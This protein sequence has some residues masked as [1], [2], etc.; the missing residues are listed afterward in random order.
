MPFFN[1]PLAQLVEHR[2]PKS[3]V[4]VQVLHGVPDSKPLEFDTFKTPE[5]IM[6]TIKYQNNEFQFNDVHIAR[7]GDKAWD[8]AWGIADEFGYLAP[9]VIESLPDEDNNEMILAVDREDKCKAECIAI[10]CSKEKSPMFP[11]LTEDARCM[12]FQFVYEGDQFEVL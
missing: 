6:K 9:C 11:S 12:G 8:Y 7:A 10:I 4:W 2:S 3:M 1:A 5:P